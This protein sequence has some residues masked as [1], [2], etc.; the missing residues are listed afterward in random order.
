[1]GRRRGVQSSGAGGT[2]VTGGE[3][4]R[5]EHPRLW[6]RL[7]A[8]RLNYLSQLRLPQLSPRPDAGWRDAPSGQVT[9]ES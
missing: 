2:T 7:N 6:Q 9:G 5:E 8:R 4:R 1:M 3:R